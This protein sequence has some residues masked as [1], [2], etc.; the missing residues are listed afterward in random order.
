MFYGAAL[1]QATGWIDRLGGSEFRVPSSPLAVHAALSSQQS[2]DR[3][4]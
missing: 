3:Q 1:E 4:N 2:P